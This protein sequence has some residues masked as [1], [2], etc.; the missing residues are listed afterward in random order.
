[1]TGRVFA[2]FVMP[3][4]H[5]GD[6]LIRKCT[7]KTVA[8]AAILSYLMA[9]GMTI[10]LGLVEANANLE[11]ISRTI[12]QILR[13]FPDASK[14]FQFCFTWICA[15]ALIVFSQMHR[16]RVL[17]WRIIV[18]LFFGFA[19]TAGYALQETDSLSMLFREEA[20]VAKSLWHF[21][22]WTAL[23]YLGIQALFRCLD[24]ISQHKQKITDG[25]QAAAPPAELKVDERQAATDPL[26]HAIRWCLDDHPFVGP[27][28]LIAL[29]WLPV[30]IGYAPG[31]FMGDTNAQICMWYGLES[32]RSNA[33]SLLD[34]SVT[35]TTHFPVLHTVLLGACVQLGDALASP[36]LGFLLY[37]TLQYAIT[38]LILAYAHN[39]AAKLGAP[40]ALRAVFVGLIIFVP[41]YSG[42]AVLA[43]RDTLFADALLFFCVEAI[44]CLAESS[45]RPFGLAISAIALSLLRSGGVVFACVGLAVLAFIQ[46]GG[47][48]KSRRNSKRAIAPLCCLLL[49]CTVNV[50]L[51]SAVYPALHITPANRLEALSVPMQQ[52]ARFV[53]DHPNDISEDERA[54]VDRILVYNG[55]ATRYDPNISDPVKD[56]ASVR[57]HDATAKDWKKYFKAWLSMGAKD[58]ACYANATL[59]NYYGYF[60][61]SKHKSNYYRYQWSAQCMERL[62]KSSSIDVHPAPWP[63]CTALASVDTMYAEAWLLCPILQLLMK[64][65]FW[66]W[67]LIVVTAYC[68]HRRWGFAAPA[69]VTMWTIV[70]VFLVGP[71]NGTVYNRYVFPMAMVLPWLIS[72]AFSGFWSRRYSPIPKAE[73]E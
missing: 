63:V 9:C 53:R 10:N 70:L 36:S 22:A 51:T 32:Y 25:N 65:A 27:A 26:A 6:P 47:T 44:L 37:T 30:F 41:W 56:Y 29:T 73:T 24:D 48:C 8:I 43:T 57:R 38:V 13:S 42:Y 2:T 23:A 7:P 15:S 11:G 33:V 12:D 62:N 19:M 39:A 64:S 58:P 61:P 66:C 31:L 35:L 28:A 55:L 69:L 20:Q 54:A 3:E 68:A 18:S 5:D 14:A 21:C 40:L 52:T 17:V 1:M 34:E 49:V 67:V 72:V 46:Y 71:C 45:R 4:I 60:Y 16:E 50:A 59:S